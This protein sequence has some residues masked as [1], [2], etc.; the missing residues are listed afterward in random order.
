MLIAGEASGALAAEQRTVVA[1]SAS[2]GFNR[3]QTHQAPVGAKENYFIATQIVCRAIRRSNIFTHCSHSASYGSG[4]PQIF[5][6]PAG[7]IENHR[8]TTR[9]FRP[10]R[11][12][13]RFTTRSHGCH[14][15]LLSRATP[16]LKQN[17]S[18]N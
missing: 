8:S 17:P 5:Q 2:Y 3:P 4:H 14:R 11:G 12:L 6:A 16:W 7:A 10:I 15:G 18:G 1:H 13:N 9:F